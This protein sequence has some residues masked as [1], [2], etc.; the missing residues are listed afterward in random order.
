MY[1]YFPHCQLQVVN[2][3]KSIRQKVAR[4]D[5]TV[6]DRVE[7]FKKQFQMVE[8]PFWIEY[9]SCFDNGLPLLNSKSLLK[10]G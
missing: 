1:K 6:G 10:K 4:H 9:Q 5:I 7:F 8:S 3:Y 2:N